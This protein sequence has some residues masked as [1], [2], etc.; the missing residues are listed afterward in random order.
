MPRIVLFL[1]VVVVLGELE[2]LAPTLCPWSLTTA[3]WPLNS[4][5]ELHP[6]SLSLQQGPATIFFFYIFKK[7]KCLLRNL[8][9]VGHIMLLPWAV[10]ATCW[11][12]VRRRKVHT[13]EL[14]C[15]ISPRLCTLIYLVLC[16][17]ALDMSCCAFHLVSIVLMT[18][19]ARDL[20]C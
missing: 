7:I 9:C 3:D 19:F 16:Y 4:P 12:L 15:L 20:P 5:A 17:L 8:V 1:F 11:G 6:L 18:N 2:A 13:D 14:F 10:V